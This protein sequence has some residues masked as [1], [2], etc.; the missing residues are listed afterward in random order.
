[1]V[2]YELRMGRMM[3]LN[4][5]GIILCIVSI[6]LYSNGQAQCT[7][8]NPIRIEESAD[9]F[10]TYYQGLYYYMYTTGSGVIVR[11]S[12]TL[13]NIGSTDGIEA[14]SYSTANTAIKAVEMATYLNQPD[15]GDSF[16]FS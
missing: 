15:S 12:E 1:M 10:V 8:T 16:A 7:F 3:I 6:L 14:W 11:S 4:F 2:Y 13:E 9:P 5:R